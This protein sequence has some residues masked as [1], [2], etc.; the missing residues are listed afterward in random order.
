MSEYLACISMIGI[1]VVLGILIGL[2][3]GEWQWRR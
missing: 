3:I 2:L 1:G